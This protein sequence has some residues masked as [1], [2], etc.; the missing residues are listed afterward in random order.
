MGNVVAVMEVP[1]P[2]SRINV[3]RVVLGGL[4]AGLVINLSE[5]VLNQIVI[6]ADMTASLARM[7]LPP[8]GGAAIPFFIAL[9]FADGIVTVWLYAA[10]RPRFGPGPRT[11]V[12]AGLA[13]WFF[14]YLNS[15]IV[16]HVMGM[17]TR[18]LLAISVA[19]ELGESI[20]AALAGSALYAE[21]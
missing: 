14:A 13:V 9:G 21:K 15:A 6:G 3:A 11:A 10:M 12:M 8:I 5:F 17:Y 20:V 7:N 2:I 18:R 16:M 19:W 1:P 4:V